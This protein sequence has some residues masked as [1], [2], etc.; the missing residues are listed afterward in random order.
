MH[1]MHHNHS[2]IT[3]IK[4]SCMHTLVQ[5]LL[6]LVTFNDTPLIIS[7][8]FC[9]C[10]CLRSPGELPV[11]GLPEMLLNFS[12]HVALGMHYLSSKGFVHR[13]LAARNILVSKDN[14]CKVQLK[15]KS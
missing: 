4:Y 15:E 5:C 2:Q 10:S 9:S 11:A 1:L 14:M 3:I 13:D 6:I 7:S 8:V 12:Q